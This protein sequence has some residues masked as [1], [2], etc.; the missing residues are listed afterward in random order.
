MKKSPLHRLVLD[1][2]HSLPGRGGGGANQRLLYYSLLQETPV[3]FL[4]T[5]PCMKKQTFACNC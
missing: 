4:P 5:W 3:P 2:T 1:N